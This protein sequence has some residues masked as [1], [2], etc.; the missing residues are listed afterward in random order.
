M[1]TDSH[2]SC[3]HLSI[4]FVTFVRASLIS[5]ESSLPSI[6]RSAQWEPPG[7]QSF[8]IKLIK[9]Q[10]YIK[11]KGKMQLWENIILNNIERTEKSQYKK[12]KKNKNKNFLRLQ[13]N[14]LQILWAIRCGWIIRHIWRGI[15]NLFWDRFIFKENGNIYLEY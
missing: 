12:I 4:K 6:R 11:C 9:N 2:F 3:S 5:L 13:P 15:Q 10:C 7:K 1:R 14:S 8:D